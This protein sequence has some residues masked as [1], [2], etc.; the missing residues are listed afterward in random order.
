LSSNHFFNANSETKACDFT[1]FSIVQIL[2]PAADNRRGW[3]S[4]S[5]QGNP[6]RH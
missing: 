2:P 5:E 4:V 1:Q 3:L 6:Q